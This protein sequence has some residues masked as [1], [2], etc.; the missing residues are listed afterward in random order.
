MAR[1]EPE[2][3]A[4]VLA[5]AIFL[6]FI[7]TALSAPAGAVPIPWKNCGA[8]GDALQITKADASAWPPPVAAPARAMATFDAKGNLLDLQLLLIQGVSWTF[9]SGPLPT[10]TSAGIVSLPA[11]FPVDVTGPPLPLAAGPYSTT[12]TFTDSGASV[13][14]ADKANLAVPV[15]APVT[16][17]VGLSFNGAP[18]FPL[19]PAAGDV[20]GV[21][22]QMNGSGGA[23]VFCM[24]MV[25]P[26][27]T[28]A[29]FV[30]IQG[31]A[32][33][34]TLSTAGAIMLVAMLLGTG[35]VAMNSASISRIDNR[36]LKNEKGEQSTRRES[37][38]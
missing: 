18:G 25:I 4:V 24:D 16:T 26:F 3:P 5:S 14:I 1:E 37:G 28:A 22:V 7:A 31:V 17:T 36:R 10:T 19:V 30:S 13:T 23:G 21:H 27:K 33:A 35:L 8:P 6:L 34:P 9:D 11:S 20:Y 2:P 12:Q 32:D 15:T 29:P 38:V